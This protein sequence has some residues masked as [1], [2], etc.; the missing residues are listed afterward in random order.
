MSSTGYYQSGELRAHNVQKLFSRIARHYDF[1][2][3]LQ[4][5]GLHRSWK[6]KVVRS[7]K[8]PN[9]N[10]LILDLACGSGDLVFRLKRKF[11]K[12]SII[13][14]DY[15]FQMLEVAKKREFETDFSRWIQLD[16]LKL[17]YANETFEAITMAYGLRNMADPALCLK[18]L[19]RVLKPSGTVCI[20]DFGKPRNGFIR[21]VYY[22]FLRTIQPAI[23]SLFF[24]DAETYRYIYQSLLKYPAQEG[25]TQL[26]KEAGFNSVHCEDLAL[27]TMSLH[28]AQKPSMVTA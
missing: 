22:F 26:L 16:G 21:S 17:P 2:N 23:G 24:R 6:S 28:S 19:Y 10:G 3:D 15:T 7:C 18:E 13:G 20:L 14:G 4:S 27:G 11:P 5:F 12:A 9:P 25:V 8:P 1:I